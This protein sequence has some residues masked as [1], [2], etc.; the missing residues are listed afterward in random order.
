M[1]AGPVFE[2][3]RELVRRPSITPE[4]AGCQALMAERLERIGFHVE[5]LRYGEVDNFWARRGDAGPLLCF[6]GHTDV[7]PTGPLDAWTHPP[8]DAEV[9]GGQLWGRGTADMKASLAAMIVAC[10]EFLASHIEPA[11]SIAFLI[12]SDEEGPAQDGTKKVI[13]TLEARGE[14]IDW[15]LVGEPSSKNRLGDMLRIGRRGSLSC[16]L[17]VHGIQGHVAYPE[18]ARNPLHEL[19]PFL[20]ELVGIEWDAGNESFPPTSLQLTN[21]HSGTGFRNVIPGSAEL[22]FN[23]RYSTEQTMEGLQARITAL[24]ERHG[25]D[26]EVRWRDA[27][28]PFLTSPGPFLDA[29]CETVREIAGVEPELSTG[30]GTSDGR[31][32]AP[33]G[34]AV[35]E[36]GPVNASIHKIDEH[37]RVD[38]LEPLKDLYL[39][40]MRRLLV[41]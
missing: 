25:L 6:A 8:F 38:D 3:T 32:I 29:V 2:L 9:A 41:P 18:K 20:Q 28:R 11:G 39:G 22:K 37:V 31:F 5:Q 1:T 15:C 12:T 13:E 4:D 33:T 7:V 35:V 40:L 19:T 17:L 30:G 21:L 10:E 27:G 24:L 36:L 23:I 16:D 34:A 14:K 26:Y